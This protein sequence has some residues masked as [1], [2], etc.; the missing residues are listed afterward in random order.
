MSFDHPEAED[1]EIKVTAVVKPKR[2]EILE[3]RSQ[4]ASSDDEHQSRSLKRK[5]EDWDRTDNIK[6]KTRHT[7]RAQSRNNDESDEESEQEAISKEKRKHNKMSNFARRRLKMKNKGKRYIRPPPDQH[8]SSK[9]DSSNQK[10]D[11]A[12]L[13]KGK[14]RRKSTDYKAEDQKTKDR[15]RRS[16]ERAKSSKSKTRE[17]CKLS[18]IESGDALCKLCG[19]GWELP[20]ELELG[21]LYRFGVCQAHLHCLMF[22]SGLVQVLLFFLRCYTQK[23]YCFCIINDRV[24]E[25][26]DPPPPPPPPPP[27]R[28]PPPQFF[29]IFFF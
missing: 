4:E 27:P 19:Y 26:L 16:E 3:V 7:S 23:L 2:K 15:G 17:K 21:P 25:H 13:T 24:R 20:D 1:T 6:K 28:P 29:S 12:T 5:R 18:E 10:K 8:E 11:T 22:S 9:Q 14:E